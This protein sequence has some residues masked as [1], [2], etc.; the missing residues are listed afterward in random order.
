MEGEEEGDEDMEGE[1][2]GDEDMEGEEEGEE[3]GDEME[4]EDD[5]NEKP[6]DDKQLWDQMQRFEEFEEDHINDEG[7]HRWAW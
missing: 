2:E 3:E 6:L 7:S 1:E 5:E 4:E